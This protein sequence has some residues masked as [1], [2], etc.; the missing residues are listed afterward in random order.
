MK[1]LARN[2]NGAITNETIDNAERIVGV[3]GPEPFMRAL[4]NG[5]QIVLGGRSSDPAPFAAVA[6]RAQLP[7]AQAWYAGKMLE[8]GATPSIPKGHDCLYATIDND[9]VTCEPT[10]PARRCPPLAVAPHSPPPNPTP[11]PP[12]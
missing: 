12:A 6:M 5:A 10:T 9:S 8:C 1:P 7:P 3:M 2:G 11:S 4:D